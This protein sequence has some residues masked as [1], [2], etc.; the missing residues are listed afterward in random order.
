MTPDPPDPPDDLERDGASQEPLVIV[1]ASSAA[2]RVR[3]AANVQPTAATL[4]TS[5]IDQLRALLGRGEPIAGDRHPGEHRADGAPDRLDIDSD[6]HVVRWRHH[7]TS[8]TPLEYQMLDCLNS[9]PGRTWRFARLHEAVWG[10][11]HV[12]HRA[13]MHSLVKRLRLKLARLGAPIGITAIRGVGFRLAVAEGDGAGRATAREPNG[14]R[15]RER[16]PRTRN[17]TGD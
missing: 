2:E 12:R 17:V 1:V 14:D 3:L 11:G 13:D 6:R 7:E 8:L 5:S 9:E 15:V 10:N 16:S 4:L